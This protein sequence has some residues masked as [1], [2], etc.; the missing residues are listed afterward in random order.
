LECFELFKLP[1]LIFKNDAQRLN[2]LLLFLELIL[3]IKNY[4]L[5]SSKYSKFLHP[6][7]FSYKK[8]NEH[9]KLKFGED[10]M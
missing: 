5:Q 2:I 3:K 1:F 4:D 6:T 10:L 7:R 8:F 9:D